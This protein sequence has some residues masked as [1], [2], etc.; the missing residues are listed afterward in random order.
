VARP[1][2]L[3]KSRL[4]SARQC[5]KRLFLEVHRKE[6][7]VY[8]QATESAFRKGHEVG[9]I[10]RRIYGTDDSVFIPFEGGLSPALARTNRLLS[11][12]ARVPIFEATLQHQG[13]LVR[14]DVLVPDGDGWRLVEVK[15]S[16]S[17][18]AE[19]YFDCAIQAW[20]F[21]R[22]GH[23]LKDIA[24]AHVD[25][26][27]VYEGEGDYQG[28][29][30]EEEVNDDVDALLPS[31]GDWVGEA[32]RVVA[33]AE[34][35]IGVG[36]HCFAPYECPFVNHCWPRDTEYPLLGLGGRVTKDSLGRWIA[37]GI[38]DV[39]DIPTDRLNE[40]Q[41]RIQRITRSGVA[42]LSP[43]AAEHLGRLG[44]PRYYLDFETV[45]LAVPRWRGT[46]PYEQLPFQWSCHMESADG[47]MQHAEFLDTSGDPPMRRFA[48]SLIRVLGQS[49]PI[50][51]YSSFEASRLRDLALRFPDLADSIT[52]IIDRLEDLMAVTKSNYYHPAMHGSWSIKAVLPTVAP[53]LD[54]ADL[55]GIQDGGAAAD[56][57]AEAIDAGTDDDRRRTIRD[58]LLAYCRYDTLAMVRLAHFLASGNGGSADRD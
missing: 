23:R 29:L 54:Y 13:V 38:V 7:A 37:E 26:R 33:G 41:Q 55:A 44:W 19:H 2:F 58:Q 22:S 21:S 1:V 17:V 36:K 50:L 47:R 15:A 53:D 16:T 6:L 51:V 48:E 28:L 8:S 12:D 35:A 40:T 25:S 3:S 52:S 5:P 56:A 34:P 14:I 43:S 46:R 57:Y 10:A 42:E 18:K 32:R 9:D 30:R 24:L 27:F 20:V 39:R 11:G 45:S 49:G 4:M 31:V